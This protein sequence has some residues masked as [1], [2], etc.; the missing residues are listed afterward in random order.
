MALE[1]ALGQLE[2]LPRQ[3]EIGRVFLVLLVDGRTVDGLL[4]VGRALFVGGDGLV[5]GLLF[6]LFLFAFFRVILLVLCAFFSL[7]FLAK[8]SME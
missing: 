1:A 7:S 3:L 6:L 8:D 2:H 5:L 4:G